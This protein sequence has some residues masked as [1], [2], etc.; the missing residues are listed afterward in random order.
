MADPKVTV[1]IHALGSINGFFLD[2]LLSDSHVFDADVTEF[3][4]ESGATI[5]DNIR[6]KPLVITMECLVS[7]AP[8][9]QLVQLRDH[10]DESTD[11]AYDMLQKIRK[12]R[13]LVSISTSLRTFDNMALQGLTIPR[14]SGRGDELKFTAIFKQVEL[15]T[16]KREKRVAI[17]GASGGGAAPD[18]LDK[19]T[20]TISV[21]TSK[22]YIYAYL[23]DNTWFDEDIGG[24]RLGLFSPTG[25]V[26]GKVAIT[27]LRPEDISASVWESEPRSLHTRALLKPRIAKLRKAKGLVNKLQGKVFSSVHLYSPENYDLIR[28]YA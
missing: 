4:V 5:T 14:E 16:H 20:K 3:P 12:D 1:L 10:P 8:L 27:D 21:D 26:V 22:G 19:L 28:F 7:N 6:N 25:E 15:V 11:A 24:W 9:G 18:F 13:Q 2:C 17:V 23:I